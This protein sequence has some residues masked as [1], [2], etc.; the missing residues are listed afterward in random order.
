MSVAGT[1]SRSGS[2]DNSDEIKALK[3]ST[4]G[5]KARFTC[6]AGTAD[7]ILGAIGPSDDDKIEAIPR[8]EEQVDQIT[9][10]YEDVILK[11]Q[12][13][14]ELYVPAHNNFS[15]KVNMHMI[16]YLNITCLP[17]PRKDVLSRIKMAWCFILCLHAWFYLCLD[18]TYN[19]V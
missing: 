16:H 2:A 15:K 12:E 8:I 3:N 17:F 6:L 18:Y 9:A 5:K 14:A 7:N 13:L 19:C 11:Y 10:L 1:G 4:R